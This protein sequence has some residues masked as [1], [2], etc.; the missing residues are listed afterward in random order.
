M[1]RKDSPECQL[2]LGLAVLS[3]VVVIIMVIWFVVF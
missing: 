1:R 3:T 2:I